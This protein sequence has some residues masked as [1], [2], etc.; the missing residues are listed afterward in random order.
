MARILRS[1]CIAAAVAVLCACSTVA[2]GP[3][4]IRTAT[5]AVGSSFVRSIHNSGSYGN[6]SSTTTVTREPNR[7]WK[8]QTLGVWKQNPGPTLL[9]HPVHGAF[10]ALLNG[11]QPLVTY[12]PPGGWPWPLEVGKRW[13]SEF[14]QTLHPS[15]QQVKVQ[16]RAVAEAYDEVSM[17]AGTFKAWRVRVVDNQGNDDIHWVS[18]DLT[19][20][21][22]QKLTRTAGHPAGPGVRETELLS[23]SIRHH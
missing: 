9:L 2:E 20:F 21:I 18:P 12:D 16:Q 17:P 19:V 10:Y 3:G 6:G 5:V 22:K 13:T 15:N 8:G 14:T 11:D 4:M 23:Q 7:E 1:L